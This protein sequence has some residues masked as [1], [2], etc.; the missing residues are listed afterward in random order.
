MKINSLTGSVTNQSEHLQ[1]ATEQNFHPSQIQSGESIKYGNDNTT[2]TTNLL[3][4][5][6]FFD[7]ADSNFLV[8][9]R[10]NRLI[11]KKSERQDFLSL[12]LSPP[13]TRRR[14]MLA[15]RGPFVSL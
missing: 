15:L 11:N 3:N 10:K 6:N 12:S 14:N 8:T 9:Y 13:L 7:T 1:S 5:F 2:T 4:H